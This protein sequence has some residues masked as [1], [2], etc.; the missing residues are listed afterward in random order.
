MGCSL[1][2]STLWVLAVGEQSHGLLAVGEHS[3]GLL[4]VG[5]HSHGLLIVTGLA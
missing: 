4:T 3:H 1:L 5:E 2:A